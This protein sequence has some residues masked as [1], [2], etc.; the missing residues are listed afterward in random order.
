MSR[1]INHEP[2]ETGVEQKKEREE[3]SQAGNDIVK[4][5]QQPE[6]IFVLWHGLKSPRYLFFA[7]QTDSTKPMSIKSKRTRLTVPA[8]GAPTLLIGRK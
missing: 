4:D 8:G 1:G 3:S 2:P 5:C 6:M 7:G